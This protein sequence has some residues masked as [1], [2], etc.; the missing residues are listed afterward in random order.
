MKNTTFNIL[1]VF[2]F[3]AIVTLMK[4]PKAL[5]GLSAVYVSCRCSLKEAKTRAVH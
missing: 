4:Q 3:F 2:L 5:C 1:P